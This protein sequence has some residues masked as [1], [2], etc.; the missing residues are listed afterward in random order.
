M[1]VIWINNA[2]HKSEHSMGL[3][4]TN[5]FSILESNMQTFIPLGPPNFAT[6]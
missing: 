5:F 1:F 3:E 6:Q 4:E 2:V